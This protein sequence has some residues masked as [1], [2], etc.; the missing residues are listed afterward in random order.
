MF[1]LVLGNKGFSER[2][3]TADNGGGDGRGDSRPGKDIGRA[4]L[5]LPAK[6]MKDA[7]GVNVLGKALPVFKLLQDVISYG[8]RQCGR[9]FADDGGKGCGRGKEGSTGFGWTGRN[10]V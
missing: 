5:E 8:V 1:Q 4:C 9:D 6:F 7:V 3:K 10:R 2:I